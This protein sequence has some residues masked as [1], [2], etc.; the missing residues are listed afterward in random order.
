MFI[1]LHITLKLNSRW[2]FENI[3]NVKLL[4][5]F[6]VIFYNFVL[7]LNRVST[8]MRLGRRLGFRKEK[9]LFQFC[10]VEGGR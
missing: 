5:V 9:S 4:K 1:M 8:K 7:I 10:V 3:S 6:S 2:H